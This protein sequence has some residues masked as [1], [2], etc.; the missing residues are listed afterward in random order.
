MRYPGIVRAAW[1]LLLLAALG[2]CAPVRSPAVRYAAAPAVGD[3]GP[4]PGAPMEWWYVSGFDPE[5]GLAFHAA[6]FRARLLLGTY[7]LAALSVTDLATGERHL[8]EQSDAPFP[9]ACAQGHPLALRLGT[10]TL[11][12]RGPGH[13]ALEAGPLALDLR[14]AAPRML[15]PPGWSGGGDLGALAYQSVPRLQAQGRW[16]GRPVACLAWMDHQWG[17]L[18]PGH[19]ARW[20]WHG[21]HLSD[22]SSVMAYR[23]TRLDGTGES[24][25]GSRTDRHGA[26]RALEGLVTTPLATWRGSRGRVYATS[27]RIRAAG[28]DLTVRPVRDDLETPSLSGVAYW[29][30]PVRVQGTVDGQPVEGT[31]FGEHLPQPAA[32]RHR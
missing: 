2:A 22:G 21:L 14:A 7:S 27:W 25:Q 31:G 26:I 6:F 10:W 9:C 11:R 17:D 16:R 4:H 30:G 3:W 32:R 12:E 23:L 20:D 1:P 15:H 13:Y 29:E 19:S 24:L 28:L 5:G 18:I 8:W